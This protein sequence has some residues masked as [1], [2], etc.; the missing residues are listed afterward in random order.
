MPSETF[1]KLDNYNITLTKPLLTLIPNHLD[2]HD[3]LETAENSKT[4]VSNDTSS[5]SFVSNND[6]EFYSM[7]SCLRIVSTYIFEHYIRPLTQFCFRR[8]QSTYGNK[9]IGQ[10]GS[11]IYLVN[12][13]FGAGIV[14]LKNIQW[15]KYIQDVFQ[16]FDFLE[17]QEGR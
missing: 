16:N 2:Q 12:Q 3:L 13:I 17:E 1:S 6:F 4:P 14:T 7:R 5:Q 9:T 10:W 8:Q 15:S 11:F